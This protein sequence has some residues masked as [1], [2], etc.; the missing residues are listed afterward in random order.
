MQ[1]SLQRVGNESGVF[2]PCAGDAFSSWKAL[3]DAGRFVGKEDTVPR[4]LL[5][6]RDNRGQVAQE[7]LST[8]V[9]SGPA[10]TQVPALCAQE[11][12]IQ[13]TAV[14]FLRVYVFMGLSPPLLSCSQRRNSKLTAGTKENGAI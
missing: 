13:G 14:V 4:R 11:S 8:R 6:S 5:Y 1:H 9:K 12:R 2:P 10:S 7:E 3:R